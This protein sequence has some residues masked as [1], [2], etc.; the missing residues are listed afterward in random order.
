MVQKG[1]PQYKSEVV[2]YVPL[3]RYF[4]WGV[5]ATLVVIAVI[6]AY[7]LG[8]LSGN[9]WRKSLEQTN[10]LQKDKLAKLEYD[11]AMVRRQLT[12][13]ELSVE[14]GRRSSEELRKS[15]VA[16]EQ[17]NADLEEQI[18]F[19][20]GLMDPSMNGNISFRGVEVRQG[21]QEN[22]FSLTGVVQQLSLNHSLV[23]GT[24]RWR[25]SGD[26]KS[27]EGSGVERS[28]SGVAFGSGGA[29]KLRFKYFQ[30][31]ADSVVLPEG[32]TPR[33]LHIDVETT[34]KDS[35]DATEEFAWE[36]LIKS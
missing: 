11:Y 28:L 25:L 16:L 10:A 4:G 9:E 33:V 3:R 8:G 24:L 2:R 14:L 5:S 27:A 15:M 23:R 7:W 31:V 20:K 36:S 26:Q 30:N 13:H 6:F 29:I 35:V 12:S 32:F 19:Y 21:A 1:T 34:G 18:A 22:E 17:T